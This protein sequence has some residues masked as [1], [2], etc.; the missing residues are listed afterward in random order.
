METRRH[1]L[2]SLHTS[3]LNAMQLVFGARSMGINIPAAEHGK[4]F[5]VEQIKIS[6][7]IKFCGI[8]EFLLGNGA[9]ESTL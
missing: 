7:N 6:I 8:L 1:T 2:H 3:N 9:Q 5:C 4:L